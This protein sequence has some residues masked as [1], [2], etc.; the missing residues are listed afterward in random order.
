MVV[1]IE[2]GV[3]IAGWDPPNLYSFKSIDSPIPIKGT[4]RFEPQE[5]GTQMTLDGQVEPGGFIKLVEAL[6]G[7]Q[8]ENQDGNNLSNLKLLLES[9]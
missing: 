5:S 6:I 7:K 3:E 4:T 9:G 2:A 8:A 1:K